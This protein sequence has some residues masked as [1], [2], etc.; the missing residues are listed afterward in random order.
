MLDFPMFKLC[1]KQIMQHVV[2]HVAFLFLYYIRKIL[3]CYSIHL[4]VTAV[5]TAAS[6][7]NLIFVWSFV[8]CFVLFVTDHVYLPM[9]GRLCDLLDLYLL[10]QKTSEGSLLPA[11]PQHTHTVKV[12]EMK[13]RSQIQWQI[14]NTVEWHK[15]GLY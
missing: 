7:T 9:W 14:T 11:T 15:N 1:I 6:F 4:P 10:S 8:F 2:T 5:G 13:C 12:W 3:T